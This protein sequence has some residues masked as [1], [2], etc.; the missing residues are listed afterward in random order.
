M[1]DNS[2]F[3]ERE[4]E[5]TELLLQGKSNKQIALALGISASTVEYHLKNIYRKL[6]VSSR[7]E[8]VLQLGKSIGGNVT[9]EFGKSTVEM[10]GETIENGVQPISTRRFSMNKK[11]AI[12]GGGL[13]TVILIALLVLVN[14][15]ARSPEVTSAPQATHTPAPTLVPI[16]FPTSTPVVTGP[17]LFPEGPW[18]AYADDELVIVNQDGTGRTPSLLPGCNF[19]ASPVIDADPLNRTVIFSGNVYL[20]QP[21]KGIRQLVY[22]PRT[23]CHSAFAGDTNS[24]LLARLNR[25]TA[26]AIPELFIYDM[27]GGKIRAQ[28]PLVKCAAQTQCD[29]SDANAWQVQWSPNGRYLAFPAIWN[30]SSTDLYIYDTQNGSTRQLTSGP[31]KVAQLWWSP[32][33]RWIV[34]GEILQ[35]SGVVYP[36]ITSLW[37][38]SV[39]GNDIHLLYTLENPSPQGVLGWADNEKFIVYDGSSLDNNLPARNLRMIDV[40]SDKIQLVFDGDFMTAQLD[41][42]SQTV[43][44]FGKHS[45]EQYQQGT[46]L[47]SIGAYT[48][49]YLGGFQSEWNDFA[50][51]FVTNITCE[52]D[53]T[54]TQAFDFSGNMQCVQLPLRADRYPSPDGKWQISSQDGVKL[55]TEGQPPISVSTNPSTQVTWCPDSTC[56]FFVANQILYRASVPD[57]AIQVVDEQLGKDEI[58]LQWLK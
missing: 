35:G 46:Y 31:D 3:S 1:S 47:L 4:K 49:R 14:K 45:G 42:A 24:G 54:K 28:F 36:S 16:V 6:Q 52:G 20:I 23:S 12:I 18:L 34:M 11:F 37:A 9:G 38:V 50:K 30:G 15:P 26:D 55:E 27:P 5:V 22:S 39:S 44:L 57:L 21:L 32:D 40:A 17:A 33:G 19:D 8:A 53:P 10:N 13:L 58:A 29:F 43:V 7:T 56:F 48:V 2:R 51:L 25:A 41:S